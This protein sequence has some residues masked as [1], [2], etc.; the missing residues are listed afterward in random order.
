[1]DNLIGNSIYRIRNHVAALSE[2]G[3]SKV[4]FLVSAGW[5][6]SIGIRFTFP[7]LL[8]IFQTEYQISL[9]TAG[10]LVSMLWVAYALGQFPGGFLGDRIGEGN[11]LIASTL[12]SV[13]GIVIIVVSSRV[14]LL[15]AGTFAFGLA[16]ALYGPTR[17]TIITDIYDD[18]SGTAVG[19]TMAAGSVGNATLPFLAG[20]IGA[21][22]SWRIGFGVLIPILIGLSIAMILILPRRTSAAL[23]GDTSLSLG[24]VW[25]IVAAVREGKLSL[26][27]VLQIFAAFIGQAFLSFYPT[28]LIRIK[29]FQP[30][31]AASLFSLYFVIGI[32][33][34]PLS[35][36][37]QDAL[38]S[39]RTLF[40]LFGMVFVG[41]I[42]LQFAHG[43]LLIALLTALLSC[44]GGIG[45]INNS[46]LS[47]SLPDEIQGSGLGLLRTV[48]ILLA[49]SGPFLVGVL[50]DTGYF[51]EA[52]LSLAAIAGIG[53]VL[54][55]FTE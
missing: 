23:E 41:M 17:Y 30:T 45:V 6:F 43:V 16:T 18:R 55:I 21:Y 5:F 31:V 40:I 20:V 8:P 53:T 3:D 12:L 14:Y 11:I 37:G 34:Q 7:T 35:G 26:I 24:L 33:V 49:A 54:V 19:V 44:R 50:G 29:D 10:L 2:D 28:Y 22:A 1:M 25:K 36:M 46:H 39:R 4:L 51:E 48:W 27:I 32:F 9:S 52:F 38:G 42:A 47:A 15:F 13:I